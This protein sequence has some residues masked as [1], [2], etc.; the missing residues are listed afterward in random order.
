MVTNDAK[1]IYRADNHAWLFGWKNGVVFQAGPSKAMN[2]YSTSG[3]GSS[4]SAGLRGN[5]PDSMCGNAVMF[6][7]GSILTMGGSPNYDNSVAT[8]TA[9]L[10]TLGDS[11]AT[12]QVQ[13]VKNMSYPRI[14]A[15]SVALPNGEVFVSGGEGFSNIFSDYNSALYP[16]MFSPA[17]NSFRV[18][19]AMATVPRNY[20]SVAVLLPDATVFVGGGG[21]CGNCAGNHQDGSIYTPPYLFNGNSAA[22]RPTI[23]SISSTS[24]TAG[25][26]FTVT[27]GAS[28]NSATFAIHRGGSATHSVDTDSRRISLKPVSTSGSTFTLQLPSDYGI[29]SPGWYMLFAMDNGVPSLAKW[30][31]VKLS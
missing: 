7:A 27:L 13:A 30:I 9:N 11:N 22:A 14:F 1:G 29:L 19:E 23:S 24:M 2:W 20:H 3:S 21:L 28:S 31:Q 8:S 5:S 12:P 17:T 4:K 25:A 10:I 26:K 16:E 6:D 18:L 15:N